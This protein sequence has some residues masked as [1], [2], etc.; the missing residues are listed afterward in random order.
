MST[1]SGL[2]GERVVSLVKL[3]GGR[4]NV[5]LRMVCES[6]RNL[7]VKV[8]FRNPDDLRDR[9]GTEF[10]AITFM[11]ES[12]FSQIPAPIAKEPEHDLAIYEFIDG[13]SVDSG[14]VGDDDIDASVEFLS[15]L[16][17]LSR[18]QE[19]DEFPPA[20]EACFSIE[21]ILDSLRSRLGRLT[22]LSEEGDDYA[23]LRRFLRDEFEP[24]MDLFTEEAQRRQSKAGIELN[25]ELAADERTLSPSDFGFHNCVRRPDGQLVFLDFEYFGWDD[26]TKTA[27]DFLLHPGMFLSVGAKR[28]FLS[29]FLDRLDTDG[30]I[31]SRLESVY[32]LWGLKWC[33]IILNEFLA[34]HSNRR[35][36]ALGDDEVGRERRKEQLQKSRN[37]LDGLN[38]ST[39]T[40]TV[41]DWIR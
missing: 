25:E 30:R 24:A 32:P 8:Y 22:Y 31:A 13:R 11:S 7:A 2:T 36:F 26:P 9:L 17:D 29:G 3:P 23:D 16:K 34:E 15:V 35:R 18:N 38:Q 37:L 33:L 12:G 5:I 39:K 20:S 4:N 6:G 28:R 40:G 21:A 41:E 19:A 27:S 14:S 1:V 10:R